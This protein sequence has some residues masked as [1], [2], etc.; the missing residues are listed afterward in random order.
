LLE[1]NVE[2][3]DAYFEAYRQWEK[4]KKPKILKSPLR[5][6]IGSAPSPMICNLLPVQT[7]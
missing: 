5:E 1:E 2:L 6:V 7:T 3:P 4:V